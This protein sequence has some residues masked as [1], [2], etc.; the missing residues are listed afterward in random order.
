MNGQNK[1]SE[2]TG[3]LAI[4][5]RKRREMVARGGA[6]G[7]ERVKAER[8]NEQPHRDAAAYVRALLGR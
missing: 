3:K 6:A 8:G 5:P 4:S 2:R 1:L 7:G